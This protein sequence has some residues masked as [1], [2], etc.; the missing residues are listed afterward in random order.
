LSS[1]GARATPFSYDPVDATCKESRGAYAASCRVTLQAFTRLEGR[2]PGERKPAAGEHVRERM[3][4]GSLFLE[5]VHE[6]RSGVEAASE[7]TG[8]LAQTLSG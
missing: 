4:A 1:G 8:G 6:V 7:E 3:G 2:T 5:E